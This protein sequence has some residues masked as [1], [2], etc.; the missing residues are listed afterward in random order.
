MGFDEA[1]QAIQR[2]DGAALA[3]LLDGT[4]GLLAARDDEG[5]TLLF[6]SCE[7]WTG[8][9]AILPF[10]GTPAQ[11]AIVDELL[12]RGADPSAATRDGWSPLH[13]AAMAGHVDL[14]RRLLAAGASRDGAL[15][16][17]RGGSPLALAL[18]YA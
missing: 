14:A 7:E 3:A 4:P 15:L 2:A 1:L 8:H 12:R 17:A 11:H 5:G 16:G 6:R 13:A 18:F 10:V 9:I